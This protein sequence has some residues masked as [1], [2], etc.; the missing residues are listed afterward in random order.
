MIVPFALF[1][2]N[3]HELDFYLGGPDDLDRFPYSAPVSVLLALLLAYFLYK[4]RKNYLAF[5]ELPVV[6]DERPANVT[7]II[8]ARNEERNIAACVSSFPH[9]RVIVVDDHSEDRTAEI[10]AQHQAEVIPAPELAKGILGKPNACFAGAQRATTSYV[11]FADADTRYRPEFLPSAIRYAEEHECV[12]VS[13][14]LKQETVT[15][16]EK[17]LI[18]YAFALYFTGVNARRV[19]DEKAPEFLANGQCMLFLRAAYE[20]LGGHMVVRDSVIE[21]VALA[22][23]LKRHRMKLNLVRAE[24]LGA[25]R[26]YDSLGA[27]WRGFKKNS[28]RFLRVNRR[29]GLQV[30]FS[31]ILLTSV[32]PVAWWLA[33]EEQWGFLAALLVVPPAFLRP[34]YGGFW[35]AWL[36]FP[37][38]YLFQLIAL[39]GM[40][41]TLLGAGTVWKGRRV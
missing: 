11:F 21:D 24:H 26:M 32:L 5:P 36:A 7:V 2:Q 29:T 19:H 23:K 37:A 38:I 16:A 31:S 27:I 1:L 15:L 33:W 35:R 34:W 41:S 28:F 25:V 8:P 30:I 3:W 9:T 20:F 6:H 12:L 17:I 22:M 13:G 4:A 18:P 10:A 14:F 39:D 40:I